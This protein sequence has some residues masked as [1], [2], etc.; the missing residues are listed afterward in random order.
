MRKFHLLK[1]MELLLNVG[2]LRRPRASTRSRARTCSGRAATCSVVAA[3][4]SVFAASASVFA[5]YAG[6]V[7]SKD[8]RLHSAAT[9]V[10]VYL[11]VVGKDRRLERHHDAVT[12]IKF[13]T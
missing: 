13:G 6:G 1:E 2:E 3:S 5:A 4:P 9:A 12:M 10:D 8:L 11:A 7:A